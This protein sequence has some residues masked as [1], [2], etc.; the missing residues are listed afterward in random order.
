MSS[1]PLLPLYPAC[2]SVRRQIKHP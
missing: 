2:S 1:M